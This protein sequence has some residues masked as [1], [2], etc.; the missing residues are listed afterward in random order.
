MHIKEIN[1]KNR[2]YFHNI[3]KPKK[4][5]T[6]NIFIYMKNYKD[7]VI[8]FTRCD[9]SK[10]V[11]ILSLDYNKLMG[12]IE[13]HEGK[14]YLIACPCILNKVLDKIKDI[15]GIEKF[16]DTNILIDTDDKLPDY[17]TLKNFVIIMTSVVNDDGKFYL[18][19]FL[20]KALC[21]G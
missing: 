11:R 9:G 16:D 1:I 7:L 21:D 20:E 17:I 3:I 12:A 15:I 10:S 8:Y 4:L 6:K 5:E 13:E 18:Q 19:L 2:V 14:K